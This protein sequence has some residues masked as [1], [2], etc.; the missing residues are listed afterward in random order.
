MSALKYVGKP[1]TVDPDLVYRDYVSI[2]KNADL[3]EE[4]I[5]QAINNGLS[6][7]AS[8]SYVSSQDAL[9]A[10]QAYVDA[11][12]NLRLKLAQ[13][14]VA[15]GIAA[16]DAT[17]KVNPGLIDVPSTQKF[18]RG[19]WSPATYNGNVTGITTEADL[20]TCGV[21]DPGYPY[22]IV[23]FGAIEGR[24]DLAGQ[25]PIINVRVGSTSGEIIARGLGGLDSYD[26][27][28]G[29][30]STDFFERVTTGS[31]NLGI[32]WSTALIGG[33]PGSGTY[34]CDGHNAVA[35]A[36]DGNPSWFRA[37]RIAAA[38]AITP[39]DHQEMTQ[40]FS[41]VSQVGNTNVFNDFYL[42]MNSTASQYVRCQLHNGL[43]RWFINN[44]GGEA[45]PYNQVGAPASMAV[46]DSMKAIAGADGI[47]K[48]FTLSWNGVVINSWN[49][50]T[51]GVTLAGPSNR[52]WAIG[53][54][55]FGGG[56]APGKIDSVSIGDGL[57][58]PSMNSIR[59]VPLNLHAQTVKTGVATLYVRLVRSGG[60]STV[61]ASNFSPKFWAMA[62]P[63]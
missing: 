4:A 45:G 57:T 28:I 31:P 7:Y 1:V 55:N 42:R 15:N 50:G 12:D 14:N 27:P 62:V 59:I 44:G 5:D 60:A 46:N 47:T 63:A 39:T 37:R 35:T 8:L 24:S 29:T 26:A 23:V 61:Q 32:D 33:N 54:G 2:V 43:S 48:K 36:L 49:D 16:L 38:D 10:T 58:T 13:K 18:V 34:L 21:T 22:K 19:P 6:S 30:T 52:G 25:W 40:V 3:T 51:S 11:G 53:A 9:N 17:G 20:F 41:T 56:L